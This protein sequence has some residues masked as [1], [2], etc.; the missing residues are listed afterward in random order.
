MRFPNASKTRALVCLFVYVCGAHTDTTFVALKYV[1]EIPVLLS[2]DKSKQL[3]VLW[4]KRAE[5]NGPH[6]DYRKMV[7]HIQSNRISHDKSFLSTALI[8]YSA[9]K[10]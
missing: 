4:I 10:G 2:V 3:F 6:L 7:L 8:M 5:R 1:A 9:H